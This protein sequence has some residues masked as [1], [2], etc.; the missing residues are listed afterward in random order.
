MA[1]QRKPQQ[2]EARP[3]EARRREARRESRQAEVTASAIARLAGVGPAAVSNWRRRH[4]DF[5]KPVGGTVGS[6]TFDLAE[7]EAW[8]RAQGKLTQVP[9]RERAWQE[10][11][12]YPIGPSAALIRLGAVLTPGPDRG[13]ADTPL[14]STGL[15][16]AHE[17]GAAEAFSFL[18]GRHLE[19]VSRQYALTP[20]EPAALM[21]ELGGSAAEVLDP[22]C[23]FGGLLD[24]AR[25]LNPDARLCGQDAEP[26][27]AALAELRLTLAAAA[28]RAAPEATGEAANAAGK[29]GRT[30]GEAEGAAVAPWRG[31]VEVRTGDSLRADAF[32]RPPHAPGADVV[33]C[34]PPF[35]ERN[36]GHEELAYDSRWEYGL[37]PRTESELAWV[38]HA[39]AHARAGGTVVLLMPPAA[40]SRRS[41][42][43]IRADL[44]RRGALRGVVALP[45]GVA[46]PY[47]IP[48]HVW[49][50]RRPVGTATP[51]AHGLLLVETGTLPWPEGRAAA[52]AAWRA[53]DASH[54]DA[55][56]AVERPGVSRIVP[57]VEL[58]DD[59]VD[60]T[61][62][63]HLPPAA[64]DGGIVGLDELREQL[65]EA[66]AR[67]A[68][69][70]AT[71]DAVEAAASGSRP[72]A[73]PTTSVGELARAGALT[74]LT[75]GASGTAAS[76]AAP[77]T[78]AGDVIVPVLGQEP[79]GVHV[80][81]EAEAGAALERGQQLL[82]PDPEAID[83]W[84]LAGFLRSTANSRQ[85]ST[86]TGTSTRLDA[87]RL[88]LPRLPLAE[89]R[90]FG[91]RFREVAEFE[92]ALRRAAAL[93]ERFAQGL[94]DGLA[95]GGPGER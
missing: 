23:G 31:S 41:G 80:V 93:G 46:P 15:E 19:S 78:R 92:Q 7:I 48:L 64:V 62:A 51:A 27:L 57:V 24:A 84:F 70:P 68:R 89:Q 52:L 34:H 29:P 74:L 82:R 94:Y 63:R 77:V 13:A 60:L 43:R 83:P 87:R 65:A 17:L 58:L 21:A 85:A 72:G 35:N 11:E 49:I 69:L 91:A 75:A 54:P 44:L 88:Q 12:Q 55:P 28:P 36:W 45:A 81:A 53:A 40:A 37:P 47:G 25:A 50:L 4:A 3:S 86:F 59:E 6:P 67:A 26:E 22:A 20:P 95:E 16:L 5:P 30:A 73:R 9:L 79:S 10:V 76:E 8:L 71:G 2:R 61:P 42:R 66:L 39:L 33:L 32:D 90:R 38:Q 56:A 1:Q 18:L 14:L